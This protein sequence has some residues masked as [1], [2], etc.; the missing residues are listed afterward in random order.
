MHKLAANMLIM[1]KCSAV[2]AVLTA[3]SI[4][5]CLPNAM[6]SA[7]TRGRMQSRHSSAMTRLIRRLN[8]KQ[9]E[10]IMCGVLVAL[11]IREAVVAKPSRVLGV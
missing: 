9:K 4:D 7:L 2:V 6:N 1:S 5:A 3:F 8:S 11:S 10:L